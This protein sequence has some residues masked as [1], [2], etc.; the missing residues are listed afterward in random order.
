MCYITDYNRRLKKVSIRTVMWNTGEEGILIEEGVLIEEGAPSKL[1][2]SHD[3]LQLLDRSEDG[4]MGGGG[5][6][7][8][9]GQRGVFGYRGRE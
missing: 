1:H 8:R 5:E 6:D 9:R 2:R 3:V 4:P 7:H